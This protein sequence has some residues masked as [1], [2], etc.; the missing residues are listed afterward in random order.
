MYFYTERLERINWSLD[1]WYRHYPGLQEQHQ[2]EYM[3]GL[4]L[5]QDRESRITNVEVGEFRKSFQNGTHIQLPEVK[6]EFG[7]FNLNDEFSKIEQL[8]KQFG[9]KTQLTKPT[10]YVDEHPNDAV[11]PDFKP[12][13][14]H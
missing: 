4:Y 7:S 11:N 3:T 9:G 10:L 5:L 2:E 6:G 13:E 12:G 1:E 14:H 8:N